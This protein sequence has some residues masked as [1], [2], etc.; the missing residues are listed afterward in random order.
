MSHRV[1]S[2]S[3]YSCLFVGWP[4]CGILSTSIAVRRWRCPHFLCLLDI[5]V[6]NSLSFSGIV[7]LVDNDF[8]LVCGFPGSFSPLWVT[9]NNIGGFMVL[10]L[11]ISR[12][13]WYSPRC[14]AAKLWANASKLSGGR[15]E[16]VHLMELFVSSR[17][18]RF[19]WA[20]F[21]LAFGCMW[22]RR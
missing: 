13:S 3:A 10:N 4:S 18:F 17:R 2:V 11:S 7:P 20:L 19:G 22:A 21:E 15:N 16:S 12:W 1:L 6:L 8:W 9:S 14:E 5:A